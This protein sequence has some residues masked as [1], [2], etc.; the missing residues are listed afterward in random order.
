MRKN[1]GKS[2][3][4]GTVFL[5]LLQAIPAQ[6]QTA[7]LDVFYLSDTMGT[8]DTLS[9]LYRVVL[10]YSSNT[11]TLIPL[12]NGL[13]R[14]NHVDAIAAAMDGTKL[15]LFDDG[16]ISTFSLAYYDIPT[17][18]FHFVGPIGGM[19]LVP[20]RDNI[21][22][23][24]VSP[25]G[26][27]YVTS[28]PYDTLL[29][30]NTSTAFA[31]EV[32]VIKKDWRYILD[33]FGAD[34]AFTAD[35]ILYLWTNRATADAPAGL[36]VL[37]YKNP[38]GGVVNATYIGE[39]PEFFTGLAVKELGN[40][41]LL[42]S[43][44]NPGNWIVEVS[45]TDSSVLN[46]FQMI[47]E[48]G[49][50]FDHIYGDMTTGPLVFPL[51]TK[52]IGYWKN[53]SWGGATVTICGLV[54]NERL[55]KRILKSARFRNFSMLFAQLIAAKLNTHNVVGIDFIDE[56]EAWICSLGIVGHGDS[57]WTTDFFGPTERRIKQQKWMATTYGRTLDN[58]NNEYEYNCE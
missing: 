34:I 56:A 12:P 3:L 33:I 20:S 46:Y 22:Q 8:N 4:V 50:P 39:T 58:F 30:V 24:A 9:Q 40:G 21:D 10:D 47:D 25:E 32:G 14:L 19:P 28:V 38:V 54:I 18:L 31:T 45:R 51:C 15:W 48:Y 53:H 6:A 29:T 26:V 35:G 27:L 57:W 42:G 5:F 16:P 1:W 23:A 55:G 49:N 13:I 36:Y 11:A 41:D 52:T 7:E 17:A 37:D 44:T 2:F 43:T